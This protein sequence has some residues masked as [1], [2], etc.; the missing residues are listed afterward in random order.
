[1]EQGAVDWIYTPQEVAEMAKERKA[2]ALCLTCYPGRNNSRTVY[3]EIETKREIDGKIYVCKEE[4]ERRETIGRIYLG[5]ELYSKLPKIERRS[6]GY[7]GSWEVLAYSNEQLLME[8]TI[9][10]TEQNIEEL[11]RKLKLPK[12]P[13]RELKEP[14]WPKLREQADYEEN[15]T[16]LYKIK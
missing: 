11:L 13:T 5:I 14:S 12:K 15:Y 16:K 6:D 7:K 3:A 8:G 9:R 1:M 4:V 2:K 10:N